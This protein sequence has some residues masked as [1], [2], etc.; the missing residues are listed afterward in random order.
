MKIINSINFYFN[1]L[2]FDNFKTTFKHLKLMEV[3]Y[4][5]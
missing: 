5:I 1:F 3:C 2:H 4:H